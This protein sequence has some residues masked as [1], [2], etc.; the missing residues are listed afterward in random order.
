VRW[1]VTLDLHTLAAAACVLCALS[2]RPLLPE[3]FKWLSL[4]GG[5]VQVIGPVALLTGVACWGVAVEGVRD[6]DGK[7]WVRWAG[8]VLMV[9]QGWAVR[10]MATC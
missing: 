2:D 3:G 10:V 7:V 6:R 5:A 1:R 9:V 8:G 4:A